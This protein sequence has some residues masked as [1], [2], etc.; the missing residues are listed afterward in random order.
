M[1]H[2][3]VAVFTDDRTDVDELLAPYDE[4]ITVAPYVSQTKEQMIE[5]ARKR[6]ATA[7][8]HAAAGKE[9]DG[10]LQRFL[11]AKTDEELYAAMRDDA[12]Y[13]YDRDGNE[14]TTYNPNSKWDWYVVG[15]RWGDAF[16][17][18]GIDP[19]GTRVGDIKSF[20]DEKK[21]QSAA[22]FWELYIDG[23][24]PQSEED[25]QMI[26]HVFYN[27]SYYTKRYGDKETYAKCQAGFSTFAVVLPDGTWHE[28]GQMGW[29][30]C[31]SETPEDGM[32]W[33]KNYVDNF[34]KT[35]DPDWTLTIVDCH[36]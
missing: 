6:A 12:Y 19:D 32:N 8:E 30:G 35:A 18:Y 9:L 31:S 7:K 28:P 3:T 36:I 22:R 1:S 4:S 34:L 2:F 21:Y 26:E 33:E 23:A 15:G 27:Q 25:R 20:F 10:W 14:L 13:K 24:E 5:S 29:F 16:D 17:A 11:N